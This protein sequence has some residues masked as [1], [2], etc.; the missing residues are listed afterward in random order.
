MYMQSYTFSAPTPPFFTRATISETAAERSLSS[1]DRERR[2]IRAVTVWFSSRVS[3]AEH[4][5]Y[6]LSAPHMNMSILQPFTSHIIAYQLLCAVILIL[7]ALVAAKPHLRILS[8]K[9]GISTRAQGRHTSIP[10]SNQPLLILKHNQ[11]QRRR[12][13]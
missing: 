1:A 2:F 5:E 7:E 6:S 10:K 3:A 4:K 11:A 12:G 9:R 13:G 8:R